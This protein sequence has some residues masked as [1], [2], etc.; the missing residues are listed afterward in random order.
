LDSCRKAVSASFIGGLKET[1]EM[2]NLCGEHD[3]VSTIEMI[4]MSDINVAFERMK[5]NDVCYCL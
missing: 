1:Q 4:D 3:V 5:D 2:L